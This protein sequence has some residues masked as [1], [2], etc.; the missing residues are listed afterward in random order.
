MLPLSLFLARR[1]FSRLLQ[2]SA[3]ALLCAPS[4]RAQSPVDSICFDNENRKYQCGTLDDGCYATYNFDLLYTPMAHPQEK[5]CYSDQAKCD[6]VIKK[7]N[8]DLIQGTWPRDSRRCGL[9]LLTGLVGQ[10]PCTYARSGC[11][12]LGYAHLC[13]S[14]TGGYCADNCGFPCEQYGKVPCGNTCYD[15]ALKRCFD[16]KVCDKSD[17]GVCGGL[18]INTD[19]KRCING[20][21]CDK[22]DDILCGEKCM[23]SDTEKC[24]DEIVCTKSAID[25]CGG[26]CQTASKKCINDVLCDKKYDATCRGKCYKESEANCLPT[27][28]AE[29]VLCPEV[30]D[31]VCGYDRCFNSKTQ[32]CA[33]HADEKVCPLTK[34]GYNRCKGCYEIRASPMEAKCWSDDQCKTGWCTAAGE[35]SVGC[36][37]GRCRCNNDGDCGAGRYCSKAGVND[38]KTK[39]R[40]DEFCVSDNQCRSGRCYWAKCKAC[41][42]SGQCRP[43]QSCTNGVCVW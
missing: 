21:V 36:I 16:G 20:R 17:E 37:Y 5:C 4:A 27:S 23:D 8:G 22:S 41:E 42:N 39:K 9:R 25:V 6:V 1:A 13:L 14:A 2:F 29:K 7:N 3:V 19:K 15:P 11:S 40:N 33:D 18:C 30:S 10:N 35:G 31:S 43:G 32:W 12:E 34:K 38:C 26:K 28:G 24:I